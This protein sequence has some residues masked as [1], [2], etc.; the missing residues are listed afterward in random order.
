MPPAQ[1]C[2]CSICMQIRDE[3]EFQRYL[4]HQVP[5]RIMNHLVMVL[6]TPTEEQ[7]RALEQSTE[8]WNSR[9][10]KL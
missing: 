3:V 9:Y 6:G 4:I 2:L 8:Q 10:R 1:C 5:G 7:R